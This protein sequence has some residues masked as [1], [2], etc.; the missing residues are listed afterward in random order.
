MNEMLRVMFE[1]ACELNG[2][3]A[4]IYRVDSLCCGIKSRDFVLV[5]ISL[6][7]FYSLFV[8]LSKETSIL[9]YRRVIHSSR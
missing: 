3:S 1:L 8:H 5:I 7:T 9:G 2:K 4:T 6:F